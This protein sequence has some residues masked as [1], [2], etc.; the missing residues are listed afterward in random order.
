MAS[1]N[2]TDMNDLTADLRETRPKESDNHCRA[3]VGDRDFT[4]HCLE[5]G[6][7]RLTTTAPTKFE[8]IVGLQVISAHRHVVVLDGLAARSRLWNYAL[9]E[10]CMVLC[11]K[12]ML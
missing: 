1:V 2:S 12:W 10:F 9:H 6:S 7:M 11:Q 4:S 5:T 3:R 8:L